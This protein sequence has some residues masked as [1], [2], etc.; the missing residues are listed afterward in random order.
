MKKK[1]Y[2]Y[3]LRGMPH[4]VIGSN[5]SDAWLNI[6]TLKRQDLVRTNA[7]VDIQVIL[8]ELSEET[9][10]NRIV[11]LSETILHDEQEIDFLNERLKKN[12]NH[13]SELRT[14][15]NA[16]QSLNEENPY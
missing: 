8:T 6:D 15:F 1:V 11:S 3:H 10:Q 2:E 5:K 14:I 13:R 9:M 12:T 16:V 7:D 4:F